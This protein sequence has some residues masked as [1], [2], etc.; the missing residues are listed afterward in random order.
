MDDIFVDEKDIKIGDEIGRGSFGTIFNV[1]YKGEKMALKSFYYPSVISTEERLKIIDFANNKEK[2]S[3][4]LIIPR[5]VVGDNNEIKKYLTEKVDGNSFSHYKN[6]DIKEKL[7]MLRKAKNVINKMHEQGIIHGEL[8]LGNM[9]YDGENVYI[10]DFDQSQYGNYKL[11]NDEYFLT[12]TY[13]EE[14]GVDPS[15]DIFIFNIATYALINGEPTFSCRYK[16]VDGNYGCLQGIPD[17]DKICKKIGWFER[18]D[19]F[20]I[21]YIPDDFFD[22]KVKKNSKYFGIRRITIRSKL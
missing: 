8:H 10:I 16:C 19:E 17:I 1:K 18:N 3:N 5:Y 9:L 2:F 21:D 11:S 15:V 12:K 13:V 20:L 6:A 4:S 7:F 14:N 22:K